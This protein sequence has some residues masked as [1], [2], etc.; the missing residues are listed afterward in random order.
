MRKFNLTLIAS[1]LCCSALSAFWPEAADSAL[2]IGAGYRKDSFKFE[3]VANPNSFDRSSNYSGYSND[4]DYS[5]YYSY[6]YGS[7]SD[8]EV[9]PIFKSVLDWKNLDIAFI[10]GRGKYVTCDNFYFRGG[11][12]YGWIC[13]GKNTDTDYV[14]LYNEPEI[15]FSKSTA[16][17][18]G[19]VYDANIAVGYQFQMC[20]DTFTLA[21]L[22]GYSWKGQHFH[23][24][25][26]K[27]N[28]IL[29]DS[30]YLYSF[31]SSGY[32][33]SGLHSKYNARWNGPFVGFDS[34]YRFGCQWSFMLNYEYHWGRYHAKA[35]WNLRPDM[36]DGF[37]HRTKSSY[38]HVVD[39]G[40]KW[41]FC[42][43]WTASVHGGF[44][45]FRADHG[46]DITVIE[47]GSQGNISGKVIQSMPL[48][49][50]QWYSA[51]I[52]LDIGMVF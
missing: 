13:D 22:I 42:E 52:S 3:T 17:T 34:E 51:S 40:V 30:G 35:F 46:K 31:G 33:I 4:Y 19:H 1:L 37:N 47:S 9:L 27:Q 36:P 38:G 16:K 10:E 29:D 12:D 7:E 28:E 11:G 2:E 41:D 25:H 43:C 44:Q 5:D 26:L 39:L 49:K 18:K 50:V 21:P 8:S 6:Y 48:R 23:D 24:Y 14:E 45:Y 32:S 15:L 20:D